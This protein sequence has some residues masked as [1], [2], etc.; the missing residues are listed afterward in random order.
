MILLYA[1]FA[2]LVGTLAAKALVWWQE[3][4]HK[5]IIENQFK[6]YMKIN[7]DNYEKEQD[8]PGNGEDQEIPKRD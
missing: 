2:W 6:T 7:R 1:L 5:K 3:R 4:N 8:N